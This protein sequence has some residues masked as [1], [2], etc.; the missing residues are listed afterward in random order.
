MSLPLD[1]DAVLAAFRADPERPLK[2]KEVSRFLELPAD[3]RSALRAMLY[4]L[5]DDG[6]LVQL[7][8][9]RFL[10]AS[11]NLLLEGKVSRT[12]RGFGWFI[13]DAEGQVD[14][15]IPPEALAGLLDGDRVLARVEPTARGP[16]AKVEKVLSRARSLVTGELHRRGESAWVECPRE[17]LGTPIVIPPGE[18][19]GGDEVED[20]TVVEVVITQYPTHVT[21]AIGRVV[22]VIGR[23]GELSVEIDRLITDAGVPRVFTPETLEAAAALPD[24]PSPEDAKGREDVRD[25]PLCTIDGET[26]K[27]FDDAVHGRMEGQ[28]FVLLVAIADVSHYVQEDSPLDEDALQRGTSVYF[29]GAVIPMLPEALSNGICSLNP[30]VDRLVLCA[31]LVVSPRGLLKRARFFEGIMRSHARLT[32]NQVWSYF[33]GDKAT[34]EGIP[35]EVRDSLDVLRQAAR[36]LR[37]A[38]QR[39]GSMDFELPETVIEVDEDGEP[40]RLYPLERNEA[41]KLIEDL[42]LAANEAVAERFM[43]RGLPAIY[44]IHEPPN[45]EKVERFLRLARV[46]AVEQGVRPPPEKKGT[47]PSSKDIRAILAPL[48]DS[49]LRRVLDFL[50]LRAMMQARYSSENVGH[51]SLAS[52]AYTH[53]TSPIRRYPDLA[54]HRLLRAHIRRPRSKPREDEAEAQTNVLEELAARCSDAE[55]RAVGLERN[56][57]ALMGAWVM[58]DRLG[59]ELTGAVSG[60]AEFGVFVRLFDPFVEGMVPVATI[61]DEFLE[62]DELRMRLYGRS[63]FEIGVGDRVTVSVDAVNVAKRQVS[64]RLLKITE[65]HGK[66]VERVPPK[67]RE[68]HPWDR[69]LARQGKKPRGDDGRGKRRDERP[70]KRGDER[71]SKKEAKGARGGQKAPKGARGRKR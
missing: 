5:V 66:P 22:R 56:I 4:V 1:R 10:L 44:R 68:E 38:R 32:Y 64:F 18:E 39:R 51:Y 53:F 70:G 33:E 57:D 15:F 13:A 50:L 11:Q 49:R 28:D 8:G 17:V 37:Q 35:L 58:R 46:I 63:G 25:I 42:M 61:A 12:A 71:G 19:G 69:Y 14:G 59:E 26:A 52:D 27:D 6:D 3:E 9:R 54:V 20:G 62:Y 43:S 40:T 30:H 55:R 48:G 16:V 29:P 45:L 7:P 34:T 47:V 24:A 23:A 21:S 60:C 31:E 67:G 65:Q 41:H 2:A 36:A